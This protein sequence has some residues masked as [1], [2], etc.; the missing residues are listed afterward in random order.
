MD[1][2]DACNAVS[3][4]LSN[5]SGTHVDAPSHF[6][7]DGKALDGYLQAD[8]IFTDPY[9]VDCRKGPDE[10]IA[11][12]DLQPVAVRHDTSALLI[13]TG[14]SKYRSSDPQVYSYHNPC[15]LPETAEWIR[16]EFRNLKLIG[17]DTISFSSRSHRTLGAETHRTLFDGKKFKGPPLLIAEDM[18]LPE[19]IDRLDQL[20]IIPMFSLPL[21]GSPCAALGVVYD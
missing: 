16:K 4:T 20:I 12:K 21:D 9:I 1:K 5:H 17:I 11:I 7:K 10:L 15:L 8:L 19:G 2:G 18:N 3:L 13:R 6:L 14:F